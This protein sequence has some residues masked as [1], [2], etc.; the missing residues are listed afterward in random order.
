MLS[1]VSAVKWRLTPFGICLGVQYARSGF[2]I[3][4]SLSGLAKNEF[5][6]SMLNA[7][8]HPIY[9]LILVWLTTSCNTVVFNNSEWSRIRLTEALKIH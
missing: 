6:V 9:Y 8:G 7:S 2:Y 3:E 1:S 4:Y 5:N